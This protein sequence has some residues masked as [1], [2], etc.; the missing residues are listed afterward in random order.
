M[1]WQPKMIT[2]VGPDIDT[3]YEL[4][5][6]GSRESRHLEAEQQSDEPT[7][8]RYLSRVD[9][10]ASKPAKTVSTIGIKTKAVAR[11]VATRAE[12]EGS[13]KT[14]QV[15]NPHKVDTPLPERGDVQVRLW[16]WNLTIRPRNLP[17]IVALI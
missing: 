5:D 17:T 7:S 12:T 10:Q 11:S 16:S 9:G 15:T 8:H 1:P 2:S 3:A 4:Y 14:I 6:A 13:M